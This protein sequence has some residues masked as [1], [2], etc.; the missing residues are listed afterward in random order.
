SEVA[1][2]LVE[3]RRVD[4]L[5]L[6]LGIGCRQDAPAHRVDVT[7][8]LLE[9]AV[10][11][12][13]TLAGDAEQDVL[14]GDDVAPETTR[15]RTGELHHAPGTRR[16]ARG[17]APWPTVGAPDSVRD[18]AAGRFEGAAEVGQRLAGGAALAHEPPHEVLWTDHGVAQ[19]APLFAGEVED[20]AGA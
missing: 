9:D 17:F 8:Q 5:G 3:E 10:G 6:V 14:S 11:D 2:V 4:G 12:T 16:H 7:R 15:L 19:L 1:G 20:Q 18:L 13:V